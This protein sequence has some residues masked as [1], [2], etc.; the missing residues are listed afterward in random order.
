MLMLSV[1]LFLTLTSAC[2]GQ[3]TQ[4]QIDA[5]DSYM[6]DI[7]QCTNTPG[8]T[9]SVVNQGEVALSTG[10]GTVDRAGS[11]PTTDETLVFIA[12]VTKHMTGTLLTK[13]IDESP[14]SV[15]MIIL[16]FTTMKISC[17]NRN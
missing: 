14:R 1:V 4:E 7:R 6:E 3:L 8:I 10:Y 17:F 15:N 11:A 16:H 12:S 2:Q 13:L 9:L 5:I